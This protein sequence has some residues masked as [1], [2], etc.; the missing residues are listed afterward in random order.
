MNLRLKA[1]LAFTNATG[2]DEFGLSDISLRYNWLPVVDAKK[3]ILLSADLTAD[4]ATEDAL[5]RGKWIIGPAVTYA[6]FLSPTIIFAPAYQHNIS[7]AGDGERK[8]V[9]ESVIDLYMV[10]TAQDKRSSWIVDPT[11]VIDW[12]ADENTPVTHEV[13]YGRN[14]GTLFGGVLNMYVRPG[15]GIG[16]TGRTSGASRSSSRWLVS[17]KMTLGSRA[18]PAAG[19]SQ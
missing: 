1:P 11:F 19:E 6:M 5:G 9:N 12:E 18:R 10:F 14:I 13:E 4:T 16:Q 3:G 8:D 15:V 17:R 2:D 7:F